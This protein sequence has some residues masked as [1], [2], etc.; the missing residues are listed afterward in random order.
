MLFI[1]FYGASFYHESQL[2]EDRDCVNYFWIDD[3]FFLVF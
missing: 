1:G 3:G 2:I